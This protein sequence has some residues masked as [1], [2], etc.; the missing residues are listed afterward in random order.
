M[1][2]ALFFFFKIALDI[3]GFFVVPCEFQDCLFYFCEFLLE[4]VSGTCQWIP[5]FPQRCINGWLS[6]AMFL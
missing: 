1:S 6:E 5:R 2:P 4:W 3:H